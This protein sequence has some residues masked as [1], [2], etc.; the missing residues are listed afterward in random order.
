MPSKN[1]A[2][3]EF[4]QSIHSNDAFKEF[5]DVTVDDCVLRVILLDNKN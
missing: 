1:F 5:N 4:E 3:I 2:F